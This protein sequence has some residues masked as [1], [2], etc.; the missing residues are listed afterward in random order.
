MVLVRPDGYVAWATDETSPA[1]RDAAL[2]TALTR[3]CGHPTDL[4][5]GKDRSASDITDGNRVQLRRAHE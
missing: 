3:W 1:S 2:R 5:N 4:L